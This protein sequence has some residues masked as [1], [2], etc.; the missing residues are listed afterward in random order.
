[1]CDLIPVS[2]FTCA[3]HSRCPIGVCG[4]EARL[5]RW[6]QVPRSLA[7]WTAAT[8]PAALDLAPKPLSYP[9][10]AT[11]GLSCLNLNRR[12][13]PCSA[14]SWS[15]AGGEGGGEQGLGA[16]G[17]RACV[18]I[19][20][21]LGFRGRKPGTCRG[22]THPWAGAG[23]PWPGSSSPPGSSPCPR[24]GWQVSGGSWPPHSPL[25]FPPPKPASAQSR[26]ED[27]WVPASVRP[28]PRPQINPLVP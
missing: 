1:M 4:I 10:P 6:W 15:E 3:W 12:L 22:D 8:V 5:P 9:F 7:D 23:D 17:Q 2:S 24:A 11:Q 18:L 28:W 19:P 14:E 26:R 27:A 21:F 20:H 25:T 13:S 16:G